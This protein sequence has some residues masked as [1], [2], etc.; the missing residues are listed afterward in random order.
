MINPNQ[1][2]RKP[3]L[4]RLLA[5]VGRLIGGR[6]RTKL[7]GIGLNHA[8]VLILSHLWHEDGQAQNAL[9]QA[10]HITPPTATSTLQRMERDGWI[11]RRRDATDQRVVRVFLT[12]KAD[13]F[14]AQAL[15]TFRELDQE[16]T[17]F[18]TEK[19]RSVL[20]ATLL[21]VHR[22]L[23]RS[24]EAPHPSRSSQEEAGRGER[25]EQ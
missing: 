16:L 8:Q 9:A 7:E 5:G 6:M 2:T 13:A 3:T 1:E 15:A 18:L 12:R 10:L 20:M 25:D 24:T 21:K 22:H 4:G 11:K 14:R 23:T 17:E 19:E